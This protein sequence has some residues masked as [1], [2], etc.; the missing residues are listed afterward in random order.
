MASRFGLL[1]AAVLAPVFLGGCNREVPKP[2][3]PKAPGVIVMRTMEDEV[4]DTE[5]FTGRLEAVKKV[6][7][8]ARV[9]GRLKKVHFKEGG[10]V[11]EG[12]IL[13]EMEKN[14]YDLE[15]ARAERALDQAKIRFQTLELELR[16]D[17][18]LYLARAL[19]K[20]QYDKKVGDHGEAEKAIGAAEAN[21]NIA[22]YFHDNTVIRAPMSGR[23]G[24]ALVDP[25]NLVKADM[26]ILTTLV[27]DGPI[28]AYFDVDERTH[29][30]LER[31]RIAKKIAT[32][33][34]D[35]AAAKA[36]V[37]IALSDEPRF[38]HQGYIDFA[39]IIIDTATGTRRLRGVFENK[40]DL[41]RPGMFVRVRIEVGGKKKM[42]MVPELAVGTDQGQKF[43]YV[44]NDKD[45]VEYRKVETGQLIQGRRVITSK[46]IKPGERVIVA[47]LQKVR[48][49]IKV[50]PTEEKWVPPPDPLAVAPVVEPAAIHASEKKE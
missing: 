27:S 43:V 39:D 28:F 45:E 7:L 37:H 46:D 41:F 20:E 33:S 2:P 23:V 30:I 31:L 1:L 11:K 38:T 10:K 44:V 34:D 6:D 32:V 47:G 15:L 5:D 22:K 49:K 25:E 36:I 40:D 18:K 48:P 42:V 16:R 14:P 8:V 50:V 29:I 24:R 26:T 19:P 35:P 3:P 12:D 9:T 21:V 4:I 17:Y 13:F